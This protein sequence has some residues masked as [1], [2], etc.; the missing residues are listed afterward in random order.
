MRAINLK[1]YKKCANFGGYANRAT[2]QETV[3]MEL[4]KEGRTRAPR[5]L[6]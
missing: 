6:Y 2:G 4:A 1:K 3:S 5:I